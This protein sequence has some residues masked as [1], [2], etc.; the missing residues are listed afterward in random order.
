MLGE[1]VVL[2]GVR[3]GD[4]TYGDIISRMLHFQLSLHLLYKCFAVGKK[5]VAFNSGLR[6]V[7]KFFKLLSFF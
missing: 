2:Q 5:K 4:G 3:M 1:G 7:F 6:Q